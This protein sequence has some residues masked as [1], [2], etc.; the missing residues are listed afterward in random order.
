MKKCFQLCFSTYFQ[1]YDIVN[2]VAEVEAT[3]EVA[4]D[5]DGGKA[6]EGTH[7][8]LIFHGLSFFL[9]SMCT[10]IFKFIKYRERCS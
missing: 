8:L 7:I 2:G 1:R 4:M 5:Q 6:G 3:N 9:A 10:L